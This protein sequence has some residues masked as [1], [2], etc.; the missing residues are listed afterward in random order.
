MTQLQK[1]ILEL[2]TV[3]D[4]FCRE[5][6]IRYVMLGGTMLGAYRHHGFIPWDDDADIGIPE[7][8]FLRFIQ[9]A[10]KKDGTGLPK[11][12]SVRYR[13]LEKELPYAFAHME[14]RRTT[15]I[16]HR[17]NHNHYA[18]G[19]YIEI[20]PLT[21]C[22]GY[23]WLQ[24]L[25][26]IKVIIDKRVLYGKIMDY[27]QKHRV[28]FKAV[29]IKY[30]QKHYT[31]DELTEQL[32]KTV[33]YY[34]YE[35]SRFVSNHLG[36]WGRKENILKEIMFPIKEYEFEGH[37]FFGVQK[38]EQYLSALYGKN[39]MVLPSEEE[40]EKGKHPA[41]VM[42]LELPYEQYRQ[43]NISKITKDHNACK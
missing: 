8:D 2:L 7:K 26:E 37:L 32:T 28:F 10:S 17:R 5:N 12:F 30:I 22:S 25:Q 27:A 1:K 29:F 3:F 35:N 40:Q 16:E 14:D 4:R 39:F 36:H 43:Q 42:D 15:Y 21:G 13:T 38:P 19:V 33:F 11:E 9:L 6:Q 18:G 20:F 41:Y 34:S 23:K 24:R 31:I